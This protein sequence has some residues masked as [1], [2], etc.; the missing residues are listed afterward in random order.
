MAIVKAQPGAGAFQ[1]AAAKQT[2]AAIRTIQE[3]ELGRQEEQ[4]ALQLA[5]EAQKLSQQREM[6]QFSAQ[7][8]LEREKREMAWTL[9]TEERARAWELEK[10]EITSRMDFEQSEKERLRK[11]ATFNSGIETIDNNEGLTDTQKDTAR[12]LLA[13]KYTDIDEAAPYLGLKPQKTGEDA[14]KRTDVDAAIKY[15]EDYEEKY[16][17]K[18]YLPK[19]FEAK[20][21]KEEET[22]A[23]YYKNILGTVETTPVETGIP[24]GTI[25]SGLPEPKT[26]E[27]YNRIPTGARYIDS[28]GNIRTKR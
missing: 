24:T 9:E 18:W 20:P 26:Q 28:K 23:E 7:L 12:F 25:T 1:A 8:A 14:I 15:L 27:E 17:G 21:T 3:A 5:I 22:A 11:K 16:G 4:K 2:K 13:S 10:M 6:A 19:A